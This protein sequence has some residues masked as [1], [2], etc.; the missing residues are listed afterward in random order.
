MVGN[1][2]ARVSAVGNV[3]V[4]ESTACI[5]YLQLQEHS[6]H[7]TLG[8]EQQF[9]VTTP[10]LSCCSYVHMLTA[11]QT[12]RTLSPDDL[13]C[14]FKRQDTVLALY[15]GRHEVQRLLV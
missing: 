10:L 8:A 5:A 14:A 15:Q 9:R 11:P 7:S 1:A 12:Q 4:A 3:A 6:T 2:V 13:T